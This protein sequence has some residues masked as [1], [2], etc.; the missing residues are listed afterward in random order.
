ML[1]IALV[2]ALIGLVALVF[3]VVTS[4][5]LVAWVCIG[6]SVLGVVLLIIDALR[7]RQRRDAGAEPAEEAGGDENAPVD[8]PE[9]APEEAPQG[10]QPAAK[11]TTADGPSQGLE[12][13]EADK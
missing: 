6:A 9:E 1:I 13:S 7:E 2:L 10:E 4:N 8:Y 5:E 11:D 3:A 12:S